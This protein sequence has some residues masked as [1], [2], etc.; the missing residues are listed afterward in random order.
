MA[1]D[2]FPLTGSCNV[3]SAGEHFS[4]DDRPS[5]DRKKQGGPPEAIG[6]LRADDVDAL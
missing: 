4:S 6:A 3:Q 5:P 1:R 2:D